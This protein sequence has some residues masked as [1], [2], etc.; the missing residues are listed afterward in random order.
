MDETEWFVPPGRRSDKGDGMV[1]NSQKRLCYSATMK[2]LTY[3]QA[4]L[5]ASS[6]CSQA[7]KAPQDIYNKALAWGLSE[8]DSARLV[9]QLI[10]ENFLSE[11]R[12]AHAFVNDKYRF[13][14]W[15]RI[16]VIH[17]LRAKGIGESAIQTALEEKVEEEDYDQ[18]CRDLLQTRMKNMSLPLS[19]QDRA[20]LY[21]YAAQRGFESG[22][23]SRA[24]DAI[25]RE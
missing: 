22:V 11:E 10:E 15:G 14:H 20:R 24:L 5:R 17:A 1:T 8:T 16:K 6:L 21:R 25:C 12:Y 19:L 18:T 2:E 7:E 9:A 3:E 4:L 23:I 13:A